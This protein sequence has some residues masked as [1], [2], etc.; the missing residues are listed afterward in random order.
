MPDFS[1][2]L[3]EGHAFEDFVEDL[4]WA[5]G[6]AVRLHRSRKYQWERGESA[7][8]IEIKLDKRFRETGNLSVSD[9][10]TGSEVVVFLGT[11]TAGARTWTR[12]C[13]LAFERLLYVSREAT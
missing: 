9:V 6:I 13:Y 5:H 1:A 7:S 3:E 11:H 10:S 12:R 8:G 2:R 4:F